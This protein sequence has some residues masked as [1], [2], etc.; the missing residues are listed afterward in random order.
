MQQTGV[1][2]EEPCIF[3]GT[4]APPISASSTTLR[5]YIQI[6]PPPTSPT[7]VNFA[8]P[9]HKILSYVMTDSADRQKAQTQVSLT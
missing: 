3:E 6:Y 1:N 7:L 8:I 2:C 5:T 4:S 9:E